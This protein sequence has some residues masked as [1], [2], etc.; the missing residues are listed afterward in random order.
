MGGGEVVEWGGERRG[1][2]GGEVG[3]GGGEGMGWE[4]RRGEGQHDTGQEVSGTNYLIS[5]PHR[6]QW[7]LVRCGGSR[8]DT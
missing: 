1:E 4:G 3:V 2:R 7:A 6:H 5:L 8:E